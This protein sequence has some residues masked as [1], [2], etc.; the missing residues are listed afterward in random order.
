MPLEHRLLP[1]ESLFGFLYA[2]TI[3]NRNRPSNVAGI[4]SVSQ[5]NRAL[6]IEP[7]LQI[8]GTVPGFSLASPVLAINIAARPPAGPADDYSRPGARSTLGDGVLASDPLRLDLDSSF[9]AGSN[10]ALG[11]SA[12]SPL[13][14]PGFA[15][16]NFA[17]IA[18]QSSGAG[19]VNAAIP[20]LNAQVPSS[21]PLSLLTVT[22]P[23]NPGARTGSSTIAAVGFGPESG[24]GGL[25]IDASLSVTFDQ[26]PHLGTSGT[27]GVHREDGALADQ[28]DLG[29]PSSFKKFIGGAAAG[30]V[31]YA[32][33]YY[34][35]IITG[36]TATIYLH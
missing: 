27:I 4:S 33:N 34:P 25:C 18:A 11:Q 36:N 9:P 32:F 31:P 10:Q 13:S 16:G 23:K 20:S 5:V 19:N 14:E 29:D 24:A 35:V 21:V 1:G 28:I 2:Q 22:L 12:E 30:G 26:E 7:T 17:G 15:N 8:P 3:L 6:S